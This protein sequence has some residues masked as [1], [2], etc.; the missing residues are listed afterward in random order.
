M[1]LAISGIV[2]FM[3]LHPRVYD[4]DPGQTLKNLVEG[5]TFARLRLLSELVIIASQALTAI[6]FYRL[7]KG[8]NEW[9]AVTTAVW[10]TVNAVAIMVSAMAMGV[11]LG[12]APSS[13][14]LEDKVGWI[15]LLTRLISNAW[16]I[17][18]LF[19][20]LWLLPMGYIVASSKRM[21]VWLGRTLLVGGAGYVI[22]AFLKYAGV[23]GT[24]GGLL[25]I[26]A[27]IGEFWMIGYL[28]IFG[29]RPGSA[30]AAAS[31]E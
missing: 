24:W 17:G 29:I 11:A 25:T 18:A 1:L 2:G 15:D 26:P 6:W 14:A 3:V 12:I 22:S 23:S 28:L 19:F 10:G 27:S 7:F 5:E 16:G 30:G 8:I 13:Y 9:A 31:G 4:A 20:G 21:P